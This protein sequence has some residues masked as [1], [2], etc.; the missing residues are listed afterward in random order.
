MLP[1][2]G[3]RKQALGFVGEKLDRVKQAVNR[4]QQRVSGLSRIAERLKNAQAD[5]S[6]ECEPL[7]HTLDEVFDELKSAETW[8]D[9]SHAV[10]S[11]ISRVS[12]GVVSSP[13]YAAS[14]Q[15][16]VGVAVVNKVQVLSKDVAD[17]LAKLQVIRQE[18]IELRDKGKLTR[19]V[20]L[21]IIA[22]VAD[23]D[24]RLASLSARIG[25]ASAS[26]EAT[27]ASCVA[28]GETVR[29]WSTVAAAALTLVLLWFGISQA[30][31]MRYGWRLISTGR[32]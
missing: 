6:K 25:K 8:L 30:M 16:S 15:D 32:A 19:E 10:A 26:V 12:E 29:W 3:P 21:R 24:E 1:C 5:A 22:R 20:A 27:R 2:R 17:A 31:M 7:L 18:L 28:F 14:H 11:G 23:L 4:S 9:S 13:E